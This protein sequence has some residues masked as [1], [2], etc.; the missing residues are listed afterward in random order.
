MLKHTE[1]H[2]HLHIQLPESLYE[3]LCRLWPSYG[4]RSRVLRELLQK[5]VEASDRNGKPISEAARCLERDLRG[6]V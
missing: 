1:P 3:D 6:A 4:E 2:S 5:H